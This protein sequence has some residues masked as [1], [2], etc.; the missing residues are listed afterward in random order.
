MKQVSVDSCGPIQRSHVP[1]TCPTCG[2]HR[3]FVYRDGDI[4]LVLTGIEAAEVSAFE[5]LRC[6][7]CLTHIATVAFS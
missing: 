5:Y 3:T 6:G 1:A 7:E 4:R 2:N